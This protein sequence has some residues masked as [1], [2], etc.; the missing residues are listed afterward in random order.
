MNKNGFSLLEL[1]VV[2]GLISLLTT[3]LIAPLHA[4]AKHQ[5]QEFMAE[6]EQAILQS[7]LL[8]IKQGT[9]FAN[10]L[11]AIPSVY[12]HPI[13]S[14]LTFRP[15]LTSE[16]LDVIDKTALGSSISVTLCQQTINNETPQ[17]LTNSK[18][19]WLAIG[20][21][22]WLELSG[23]L[24]LVSKN[25]SD[26]NDNPK[27]T[28]TLSIHKNQMIP[29]VIRP[30]APT[31]T[32]TM[33]LKETSLLIPIIDYYSL[34]LNTKETLRRVSHRTK[35]NQPV[36]RNLKS[37]HYTTKKLND[38]MKQIQITLKTNNHQKVLIISIPNP[39]YYDHKDILF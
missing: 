38:A 3:L 32:N 37:L 24:K 4:L 35:E 11:Y 1:L 5:Q 30:N 23:K 39:N 28:G 25:S 27:L 15:L 20:I 17:K 29:Q 34:S 2:L 10:Q 36:V 16:R 26:C 8:Q 19:L 9:R 22:G 33:L 13:E 12:V 31:L 6:K 14:R 18:L 21:H 7:A